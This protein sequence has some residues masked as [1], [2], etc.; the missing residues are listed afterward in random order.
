MARQLLHIMS[1]SVLFFGLAFSQSTAFAQSCRCESI[2]CSPCEDNVGTDFYTEACDGGKIKSCQRPRCELKKDLPKNC[3]HLAPLTVS[4]NVVESSSPEAEVAEVNKKSVGAF[5]IVRGDVKVVSNGKEANA[6]VG[7]T[8]FERDVIV[9][10]AFSHAKIMF[11]DKNTVNVTPNSRLKVRGFEE[12][13]VTANSTTTLDL[14]YGKV[15]S[16]VVTKP[17]RAD[18]PSF[19]IRT[20]SAVA[21][22]R[23]T[24]FIVTHLKGGDITKVETLKGSVELGGHRRGEKNLVKK[25]QYASYVL[26]ASGGRRDDAVINDD[27]IGTWNQRGFLTPVYKLSDKQIELIDIATDYRE[28]DSDRGVA[29]LAKASSDDKNICAEP[30]GAFNQCVWVCVNNPSGESKCRTDLSSVRCIRK[31]CDANGRWSAEERLPASS[32]SVKCDAQSPVVGPC[33]Y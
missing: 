28:D 10:D 26:L 27:D 21:G 9:T 15:R 33:D 18:K 11:L 3:A 4:Q 32:G 19:L 6:K 2:E 17:R 5:F 29:N 25:G 12:A 30:R 24:D 7:D 31:K 8:V 14:I 23:G 13:G 22:V 1:A 20:P 16:Q